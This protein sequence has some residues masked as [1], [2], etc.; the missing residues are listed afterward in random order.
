MTEPL[1]GGCGCGAVRFEVTEP[2][3]A[4]GYCHCTRC[5]HRT[6][7]AAAISA[8]VKPGSFR[9]VSGED[10]L[11]A[12]KPAGG[13]EKWFCGDCGSAL[14]SRNPDDHEQVGVRL[15]AFDRDP[16]VRPS[17]HQFVGYAAPWEPIP[18]DG[19]PRYLEGG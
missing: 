2:L 3:V 17:W 13:F 19:L 6:G 18:D 5:Q 7:T 4:A 16:G 14:F 10:R 9:V 8:S 11:R 15:G 1:T 12:W